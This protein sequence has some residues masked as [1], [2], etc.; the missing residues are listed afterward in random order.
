M[1]AQ[2]TATPASRLVVAL[3]AALA[4]PFATSRAQV[5]AGPARADGVRV[6]QALQALRQGRDVD[7]NLAALKE[8]IE[9]SRD[10]AAVAQQIGSVLLLDGRFALAADFLALARARR[11]DDGQLALLLG[12]AQ[13][14]L[15]QFDPA[16]AQLE[17]A[18][19]LL[20]A[21]PRPQLHQFLAISLMGVQR[22]DQAEQ[23]ARRAIAEATQWN[24]A[25]P[26]GRAPLDV[27][28]FE[29]TLAQVLHVAVR[30][31]DALALLTE[32]AARA[33]EPLDRS[34]IEL[35]RAKILDT[36]GD[37]AG[38][39]AAF[40]AAREATP[41][42]VEALYEEATFLARRR[43]H[44]EAKPLLEKVVALEPDHEGAWF[45]L[46]RLLP[47]LGDAAGGKRAMERYSTV[48]AAKLADDERMT[49]LR[50]ALDAKK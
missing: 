22:F 16:I 38:A 19:R 33:K 18:E 3:V 31:G 23:R 29:L 45:N 34:K 7:A 1:S 41:E 2:P 30:F 20:P 32:L 11:P 49:E 24:A 40:A 14:Q 28:D 12:R 43:R 10:P 50:R 47:R 15:H 5:P 39:A 21:G 13:A 36:R 35:L 9:R 44:A 46:A 17:E 4:A 25:L 27:V 37:E 42:R 6:E 8:A 26:A 48:H